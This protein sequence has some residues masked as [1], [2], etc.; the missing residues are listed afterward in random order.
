MQGEAFDQTAYCEILNHR[1]V[2][3]EQHH[4]G[5]AGIATFNVME[6]HS[7]TLDELSDRR[8]PLLR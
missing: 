7:V 6:P 1:A 2:A 3:V 8:V 4:A 5:G